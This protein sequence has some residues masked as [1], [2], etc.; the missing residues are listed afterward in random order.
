MRLIHY[1]Y[2]EETYVS[3]DELR[4]VDVP[5]LKRNGEGEEFDTA[6]IHL[7]TLLEVLILFEEGCIIYDDLCV[8]N[9]QL[10][11][12]IVDCFGRLNTA[13]GLFQVNVE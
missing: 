4:Q 7:E 5:D 6:F 3:L 1:K 9:P 8:R 11:Y 10:K 2:E 13:N 12:F